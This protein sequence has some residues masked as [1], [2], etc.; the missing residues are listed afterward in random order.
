MVCVNDILQ[1]MWSIAPEEKKEP[2]D[3]VGLLVGRSEGK[4]KNVLVALDITKAV[5]TEAQCLGAELIV[6]HHPLIWD[7]YK[8]VTDGVLQQEKVM[9]LIEN[10]IAAICMHTNLDEAEDGVDD[11]LVEALGLTPEEHLAEDR[12]GHISI[13]DAPVSMEEYL[14]EVAEKLNVN[15]LRYV[16]SGRPVFRVA[17]GCGSCGEYLKEAYAA[18][19]DTF[20]T[21]D[22]KHNVFLDAQD[23]GMNLIDAGHFSTENPIVRK[24]AKKLKKQFPELAIHISS[25]MTQP[26]RFFVTKK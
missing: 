1:Y 10:R 12:I 6:S 24:I 20:I 14:S 5:I 19:C 17:T 18:G 16:D 25:A 23:L 13:L 4:V 11:T 21:G 7:T 15:G 22:V 8:F 3:N 26:E 9:T 2:W